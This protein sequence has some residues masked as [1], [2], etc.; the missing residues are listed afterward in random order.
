MPQGQGFNESY[1][2]SEDLKTKRF[3]VVK[4]GT[5]TNSALLNDTAGGLILGVLQNTGIDGSTN[6]A[7]VNIRKTG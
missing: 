6:V 1:T 5:T 2:V 4:Q 3:F 7:H